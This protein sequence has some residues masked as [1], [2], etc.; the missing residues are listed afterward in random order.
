MFQVQWIFKNKDHG[1]TSATASL[2]MITMWDVE[3]GLPQID[4]YLYTS[5]NYIVAGALLAIGMV[6]CCVHNE[7][8]PA[9]A[10]IYDKVNHDDPTVRIGAVMGLG[11]AYSG[12]C[13]EEIEELL[14]P[15]VVDP[16]V[17]IE[18][19]GFAALSL[20]LVFTSTCHKECVEAISQVL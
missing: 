19:A 12:T 16:D 17:S 9:Y 6:N 7:N 15:L 14:I 10:L 3:G 20:G 5:D 18:L 13:R 8:D 2:G 11:L 4:K 1:K